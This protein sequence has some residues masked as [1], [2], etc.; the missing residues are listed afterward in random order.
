M[1]V[2]SQGGDHVKDLSRSGPIRVCF[3]RPTEH[4]RAMLHVPE[5]NSQQQVGKTFTRKLLPREWLRRTSTDPRPGVGKARPHLLATGSQTRIGKAG[6]IHGRMHLC[7]HSSSVL[8]LQA[9]RTQ[10]RGFPHARWLPTSPAQLQPGG[11]FVLWPKAHK[12]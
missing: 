10:N 12:G 4:I 6:L 5:S 11:C 1:T 9:G 2:V 3:S 7:G 8:E